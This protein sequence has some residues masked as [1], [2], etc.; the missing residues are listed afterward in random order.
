[1]KTSMAKGGFERYSSRHI[2]FRDSRTDL[3]VI[4]AKLL[5]CAEL[6]HMAFVALQ[7]DDVQPCGGLMA[8]LAASVRVSWSSVHSFNTLRDGG[9]DYKYEVDENSTGL[10][11]ISLS[12]T[13]PASTSSSIPSTSGVCVPHPFMSRIQLPLIGHMKPL[14]G[15]AAHILEARPETTFTILTSTVLYKNCLEEIT[16]IGV[17]VDRFRCVSPSVR[18]HALSSVEIQGCRLCGCSNGS[19]AYHSNPG[20]RDCLPHALGFQAIDLPLWKGVGCSTSSDRSHPGCRLLDKRQ[21]ST[22]SRV[23]QPF[24]YWAF[25]DVRSIAGNQCCIASWFCGAAST[26]YQLMVA[27][28]IRP[29]LHARLESG[30]DVLKAS[31][32]VIYWRPCHELGLIFLRHGCHPTG[33]WSPRRVCPR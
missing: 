33:R 14:I 8:R 10:T 16:R 23:H 15:F 1:M 12:P 9:R 31:R 25:P 32:A 7:Y 28:D 5:T 26:Y 29:A 21:Q 18:H 27:G 13:W 11:N 19:F 24:A 20:V 3:H 6:R 4:G 30:M 2:Q 22:H 17:P